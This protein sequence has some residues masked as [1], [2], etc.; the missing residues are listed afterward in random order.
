MQLQYIFFREIVPGMANT[1]H[2]AVQSMTKHDKPVAVRVSAAW[3]A[4]LDDWRM[5]QP[6]PPSRT[7]VIIAAV[8]R[9]ISD[10]GKPQEAGTAKAVPQASESAKPV[11]KPQEAAGKRTCPKCGELVPRIGLHACKPAAQL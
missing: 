4:A 5:M 7:A 1:Q 9:L 2:K 10:Q 11:R 3:L 6:V 8:E